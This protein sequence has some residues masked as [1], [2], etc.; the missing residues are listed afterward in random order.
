MKNQNG[1]PFIELIIMVII[2][3]IVTVSVLPLITGQG[4]HLDG[5]SCVRGVVIKTDRNG[6]EFQLQ[7]TDGM[8]VACN[9]S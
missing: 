9:Q 1:F 8:P 2:I 7:G 6:N 5:T 3:G 4:I